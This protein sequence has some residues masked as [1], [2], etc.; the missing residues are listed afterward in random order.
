[1]RFARTVLLAA[2]VVIASAVSVP[3]Q[4]TP[5][6]ERPAA[7]FSAGRFRSWRAPNARTIYILVGRHRYYRLDLAGTC[8]LLLAPGARL[9]TKFFGSEQVCSPLDWDLAVSLGLE[10]REPCIVESMTQ[11]T[12]AQVAGIPKSRRP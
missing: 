7:C 12:P 6:H 10:G 2:I 1:M 9:V 3:A 8:P 5:P 11:L 4:A